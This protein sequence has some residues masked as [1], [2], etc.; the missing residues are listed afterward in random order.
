[1]FTHKRN[2]DCVVCHK[3]LLIRRI[4]NGHL[5]RCGCGDVFSDG[6]N[7]DRAVELPKP[8]PVDFTEW[9]ITWTN[10][11]SS[12]D[13]SNNVTLWLPKGVNPHKDVWDFLNLAEMDASEHGYKVEVEEVVRA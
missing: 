9:N 10:E 4:I 5:L 11:A 7:M 1:M 13:Q 2:F 12:G 3:P 6:F 8:I